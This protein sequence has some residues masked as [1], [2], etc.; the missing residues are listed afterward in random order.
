MLLNP[1]HSVQTHLNALFMFGAMV[2]AGLFNIPSLSE[3]IR[4]D[5]LNSSDVHFWK[6]GQR[7]TLEVNCPYILGHE[8]AGTVVWAGEQVNDL[9]VGD[10]VAI[11]PGVPCGGCFQC[12]LGRYNLRATVNFSGAPPHNGSIR[13]FHTHPAKFLHKLPNSLSYADGALLEPLSVVLH[14]YERSPI[15]LDTKVPSKLHITH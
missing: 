3:V 4:A 5:F 14:G 1:Q 7:G 2:F 8:G 13:R 10:R 6:H 12:L 9:K 15:R 11:E